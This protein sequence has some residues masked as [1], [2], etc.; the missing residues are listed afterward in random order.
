MTNL[1]SLRHQ[2]SRSTSPTGFELP[3]LLCCQSAEGITPG[4]PNTSFTF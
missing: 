3:I 2:M 4:K 1:D